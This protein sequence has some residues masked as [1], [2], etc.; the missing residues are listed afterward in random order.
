MS[1]RR[2][3]G[4][5]EFT[6]EENYGAKGLWKPQFETGDKVVIV[7]RETLERFRNYLEVRRQR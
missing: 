3:F 5:D 1:I 4:L 2:G 6:V 7:D